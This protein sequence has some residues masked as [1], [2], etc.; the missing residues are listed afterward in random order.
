MTVRSRVQ[1]CFLR[2]ARLGKALALVLAMACQISAGAVAAPSQARV[3][4]AASMVLCVAGGQSDH[5]SPAPAHHQHLADPALA[6][7]MAAAHPAALPCDVPVLPA[8]PLGRLLLA[9][10]ATARAPPVAYPPAFA[11]RAPPT[12]S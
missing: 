4:L 8:P 5:H 6:A 12:L 9:G 2:L 7:W 11:A 1:G 3:S 10:A